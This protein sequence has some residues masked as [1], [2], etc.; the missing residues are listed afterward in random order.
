MRPVFALVCVVVA[1]FGLVR[2][3]APAP[4]QQ[5]PATPTPTPSPT[6]APACTPK[7]GDQRVDDVLLHVPPHPKAPLALVLAFHGANGNGDGFANES[8]LSQ[9]ADAHGFA[10]VYPKSAGRSWSLNRKMGTRDIDA[11]RALIPRAL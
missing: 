4:A 3:A 1:A 6:S 2:L 9:T 8:G 7:P 11:V 10:V 5:D